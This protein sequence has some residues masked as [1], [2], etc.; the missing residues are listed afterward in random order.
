MASASYARSPRTQSR[1]LRGRPRSP[2]S[3]RIASTSGNASFECAGWPGQT[4]GEWYA[5]PVANQMALAPALGTIGRIGTCLLS[6]MHRA[7][8]A[9]IDHRPRPINPIVPSQPIEH[10]KVNQIPHTRQLPVA[11]ASPARHPSTA[12]QFLRQHLPPFGRRG[13]MGINGST[14]SHNV[15]GSSVAAIAVQI[16]A[17]Q[18]DR[19]SYRRANSEVL[20]GSK[21]LFARLRDFVT[22]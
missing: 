14:R 20:L 16:T 4:N 11:Q 8:R 12:P 18:E 7:H 6:A 1:R 13:G 22:S 9:T 10:R 3:D 21:D 15:S 2:W 19:F 17:P 5:T